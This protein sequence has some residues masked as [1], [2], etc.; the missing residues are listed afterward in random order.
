MLTGD[1]GGAER[2]FLITVSAIDTPAAPKGSIQLFEQVQDQQ[3]D[4]NPNGEARIQWQAEFP[5]F[6][7]GGEFDLKKLV[8]GELWVD[9][10]YG[11]V[12]F[13]LEYRPDSEACWQ[14]WV[15]WKICSARNSCED[16]INPICYPLTEYGEGY[17]TPMNFPLPP[18][19]CAKQTGRPANVAFQ[20]QPRLTIRGFCRLRG[21]QLYAEP[22]KRGMY[23]SLV[24]AMQKIIGVFE[25]LIG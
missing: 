22:V 5:A 23:Q 17:K 16:V 19:S 2:S 7:F 9:R 14:P 21:I 8:G 1:F 25:R 12:V 15:E 6:T 4:E 3:F 20:F 10:V 24:C 13:N 18:Q 11:E